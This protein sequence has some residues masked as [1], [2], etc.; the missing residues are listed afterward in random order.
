MLAKHPENPDYQKAFIMSSNRALMGDIYNSNFDLGG[1]PE[2]KRGFDFDQ[3][4][5]DAG[6]NNSNT[7]ARRQARV[8]DRILSVCFGR[9]MSV[10]A[11]GRVG[12]FPSS[13]ETGNIVS[14]FSGGH[15]LYM[16]RQS[17]DHYGRYNFL[18]PCFVD[19]LMDGEAVALAESNSYSIT[20]LRLV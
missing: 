20:T 10:T 13:T 15:I 16:L 12:V 2:W 7:E 1:E 5:I 6:I 19:G 4:I 8:M 17:V 3:T 9:R 11:S 18:G 14:A